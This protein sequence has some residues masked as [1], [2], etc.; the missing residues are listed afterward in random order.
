MSGERSSILDKYTRPPAPSPAAPDDPDAVKEY[1]AF[2][3]HAIGV[4]ML[5]LIQPNGDRI[6]LPYHHIEEVTLTGGET[7]ELQMVHHRVRVIGRD[8]EVIYRGLLGH[9]VGRIA[10]QRRGEFGD[11]AGQAVVESVEIERREQ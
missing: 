7:I 1:A 3:E 6:G 11:D 8:L 4:P 5:D 2:S 9:R 10:V